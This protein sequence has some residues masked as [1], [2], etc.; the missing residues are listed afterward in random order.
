MS[1]DPA[2]GPQVNGGVDVA[3]VIGLHRHR[4]GAH[5]VYKVRQ[6]LDPCFQQ[7][8]VAALHHRG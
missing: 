3:G 8:A 6:W 5:G 1:S 7:T 4:L 2:G